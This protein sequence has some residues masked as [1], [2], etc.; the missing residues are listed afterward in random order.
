MTGPRSLKNSLK[1]KKNGP[2]NARHEGGRRLLLE[3][4]APGSR[5]EE[6]SGRLWALLGFWTVLGGAHFLEEVSRKLRFLEEVATPLVATPL[7]SVPGLGAG[8]L[9]S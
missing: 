9:A 1:P 3:I 7:G 8:G 2:A 6:A 4:E 5:V